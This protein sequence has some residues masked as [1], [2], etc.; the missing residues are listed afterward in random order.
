[1]ETLPSLSES[2]DRTRLALN[3]CLSADAVFRG[4]E[5]LLQACTW[6]TDAEPKDFRA[7]A[8]L[9]RDLSLNYPNISQIMLTYLPSLAQPVPFIEIIPPLFA[10][11][12]PEVTSDA[13]TQLLV[14]LQADSRLTIPVM[15][16]MTELPLPVHC[17]QQLVFL[18]IN[19]FLISIF[20][21]LT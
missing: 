9:I 4:V 3:S 15:A 12:S 6:S 20:L 17:I 7:A 5:G 1:M 21:P 16:A 2:I 19:L 11:S 18:S 13:V 14:V 10:I 8:T